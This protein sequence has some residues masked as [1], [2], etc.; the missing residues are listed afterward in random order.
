MAVYTATGYNTNYMYLQQTAQTM[1]NGLVKHTQPS[2]YVC[3]YIYHQSPMQGM[4]GQLGYCG[5]W[6]SGGFDQGHSQGRPQ[7]STYGSPSLSSSEEFT[8]DTV[9]AWHVGPPP[10]E[11]QVTTNHQI[12]CHIISSPCPL[13]RMVVMVVVVVMEER[14]V[15]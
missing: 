4:G 8:V 11:E 9:E 10:D 1:P 3:M 15:Y 14:K 7:C 2:F 12:G 6:L 5:L 13:L